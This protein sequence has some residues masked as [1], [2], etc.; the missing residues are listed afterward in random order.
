[1]AS[2]P[3]HTPAPARV[4][5]AIGAIDTPALVLDLDVFETNLD[6]MQAWA[7]RHGVGLRAHAK[8]H[9]CPDIALR[10]IARGA[11]GICC[12]KVTEAVP[13]IQA[14]V[15]DVLISNQVVGASKLTL[16][17]A[18]THHA[19]MGVCVD[20]ADNLHDIARAMQTASTQIDI[21]VEIDVGQHRCGVASPDDA[22]TLA[23]IASGT[24]G[25]RFRG[26]QAYHGG[27][28]HM[29]DPAARAEICR[30]VA[31]TIKT[32]ADHLSAA[33]LPAI[34]TISGAGTGSAQ[35]DAAS[36]VFTELQ[37]GSYAFMDVD[38][39]ANDWASELRFD[40]SLSLLSTV[41][42]VATPGQVVLDAGL[43]AMTIE[44]GLPRVMQHEGLSVRQVNDEHTV[45]DVASHAPALGEK[46][47]LML[48][49][50]DPA[51][52]LHD[53]VVGVRGGRVE[54]IWPIAARG[55]G[56]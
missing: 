56:R 36:S 8:A 31:Q 15:G 19:R 40:T 42:S 55:P 34:A 22:L 7:D 13:F 28:Q 43:K 52:N 21:L 30:Q 12:Q 49:H 38:Y 18:L 53:V 9:K 14:G 45:L 2:S 47:H 51:F 46:V 32:Y 33:G 10:Q 25:L 17:A 54:A 39:N 5:D 37:A 20:D 44:S 35:F 26:F 50:V 11:I 23:R 41:M 24:P 1:M 29:R 27:V 3:I 4:G 6:R 16:L 48:P